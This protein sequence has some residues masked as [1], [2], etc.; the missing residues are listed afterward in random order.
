MY[1]ILIIQLNPCAQEF[2]PRRQSGTTINKQDFDITNNASITTNTAEVFHGRQQE[3]IV[4]KMDHDTKVVRT[5]AARDFI[6]KHKPVKVKTTKGLH[7]AANTIPKA[8]YVITSVDEERDS[9][10]ISRSNENSMTFANI[11]LK[12][13][14]YLIQS[15][16]ILLYILY[17]CI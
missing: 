14:I 6:P 4:K 15:F 8:K 11:I 7:I 9:E 3:N 2:I 16:Y 5:M 17:T 10:T 1:F 12:I 13:V